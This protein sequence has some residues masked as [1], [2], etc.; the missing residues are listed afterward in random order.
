MFSTLDCN[1]S[2]WQVA[3]AFKD[4]EKTAFGCYEGAFQYKRMPCGLTHAPASFQREL[5]LILSGVKWQSCRIFRAD[6]IVYS[7]TREEHV[8]HVNSV[9]RLLRNT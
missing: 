1:S 5:G 9:L 7:E 2:Y 3:L 6:V 4:R 8:G